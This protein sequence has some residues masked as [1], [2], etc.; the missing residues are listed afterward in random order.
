MFIGQPHTL[1]VYIEILVLENARIQKK[2]ILYQREAF[3]QILRQDKA[4]HLSSY[5][6]L[7]SH[8]KICHHFDLKHHG[9]CKNEISPVSY[10]QKNGFKCVL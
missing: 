7:H 9:I 2:K 1:S 8:V 4:F 10:L 3:K 5:P 6:I